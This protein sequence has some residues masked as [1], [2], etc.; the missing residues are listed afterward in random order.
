MALVE[1]SETVR[2]SYTASNFRPRQ[3]QVAARI[4]W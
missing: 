2:N 3:L 1:V 4:E